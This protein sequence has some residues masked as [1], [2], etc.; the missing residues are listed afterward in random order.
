[1]Y[2]PTDW[3]DEAVDKETGETLQTGT[4]LSAGNF[5]N[6]E[7]GISD[8]NLAATVMLIAMT[9]VAEA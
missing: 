4:P 6:M 3:K 7:A 5:N 8:T 9:Q 2:T 1:M